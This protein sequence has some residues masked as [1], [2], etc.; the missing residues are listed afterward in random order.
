MKLTQILTYYRFG[1]IKIVV[2]HTFFVWPGL[3]LD[4]T[5][6]PQGLFTV[7]ALDRDSAGILQGVQVLCKDSARTPQKH[8][9]ECKVLETGC[10]CK[11]ARLTSSEQV[12]KVQRKVKVCV[13]QKNSGSLYF[14]SK[15][16][17]LQDNGLQKKGIIP[18]DKTKRCSPCKDGQE[19]HCV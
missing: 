6:T 1:S 2:L 4:T 19:F 8:V 10:P 12:R 14:V 17:Y 15:Y 5:G 18:M 13:T 3:Y 11:G 9:G 7:P 16:P